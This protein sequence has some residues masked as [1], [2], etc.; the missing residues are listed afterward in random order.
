[1]TMPAGRLRTVL[2]ASLIVALALLVA[3]AAWTNYTRSPNYSLAQLARAVAVKD[4]NGVQ[5]YVDVE[6]VVSQQVD[7]ATTE[8]FGEDDTWY[9]AVAADLAEWAKP[10]LTHGAKDIFQAVVELGP[11]RPNA[12]VDLAGLSTTM[13]ITSVTREGDYALVTLEAPYGN[14]RTI[15]VKLGMKRVDNLWK[16]IAIEDIAEAATRGNQ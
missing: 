7:A 15:N 3:G 13:S 14:E 16:V 4:W 2:W 12:T 9:G 6:A 10:G 1:M 11:D 8:T 5:K